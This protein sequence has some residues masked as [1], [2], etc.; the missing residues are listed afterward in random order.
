MSVGFA[1]SDIGKGV[2]FRIDTE[3]FYSRIASAPASNSVVLE[4]SS[5]LPSG[6]G[7]VAEL[8]VLDTG[9]QHT[10]QS[11]VAEVRSN[12]PED[13]GSKLT[14]D[15][16][17][18]A[19]KS[20]TTQYGKD[21]PVKIRKRIQGTDSKEY[22]LST[23]LGSSYIPGFTQ[24]DEVEYP[25]GN[26]PRTVLRSDSWEILDDGTAQDGSNLKLQFISV[27]PAANQYFIVSVP[28][29]L[30]LPEVGQQNFPDNDENFTCITLLTSAICCLKLAAA[31]APST[32]SSISADVVNYHDKSRKYTDLARNYSKRYAQ[33]VF[34][35]EEPETNTVAA[36]AEVQFSTELGEGSNGRARGDYLFHPRQGRTS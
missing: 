36:F 22:L 3:I 5:A 7:I 31:Y 14:D 13:D 2:V 1:T 18:S 8:I 29:Q 10:Y 19:L 25:S 32:D 24:L 12:V 30:S 23:I 11:Y 16:I 6:N 17:K 21:R 34:G 35:D 4:N 15:S 9:E 20:A 27:A 28:L 33:M 26:N